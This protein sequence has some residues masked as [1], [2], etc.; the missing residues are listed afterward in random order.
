VAA[1]YLLTAK[2]AEMAAFRRAVTDWE[3]LHYL[4]I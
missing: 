2:R 4:D 1:G 3:R